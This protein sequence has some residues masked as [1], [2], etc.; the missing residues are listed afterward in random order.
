MI[1]IKRKIIK[2]NE[3]TVDK[4]ATE[5]NLRK[6]ASLPNSEPAILALN[7]DLKNVGT[8]EN[9]FSAL[10]WIFSQLGVKDGELS[11][12]APKLKSMLTTPAPADTQTPAGTQPIK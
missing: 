11:A 9:R 1:K 6:F 12:I 3:Q 7:A 4:S 8:G 5:K 2:E 10:A